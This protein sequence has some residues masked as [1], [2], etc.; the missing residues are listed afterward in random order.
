ML[1]PAELLAMQ[2][3]SPA[4]SCETKSMF[5]MLAFFPFN[6]ETPFL[7]VMVLLLCSQIISMGMSPLWTV[8]VNDAVSP[9]FTASSPKPNGRI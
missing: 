1:E 7:F 9:E 8:Q 2:E 4:F 3:Y 6:T 5:N